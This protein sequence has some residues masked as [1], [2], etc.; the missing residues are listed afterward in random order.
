MFDSISKYARAAAS[1]GLRAQSIGTRRA[2]HAVQVSFQFSIFLNSTQAL[3]EPQG[4]IRLGD[5][6]YGV[7]YRTSTTRSKRTVAVKVFRKAQGSNQGDVF[8]L[9]INREVQ[10]LR[11]L[12]GHPHIVQ[13]LGECHG[14]QWS[15]HFCHSPPPG[16]ADRLCLVLEYCSG[17]SLLD[18][19]RTCNNNNGL[20]EVLTLHIVSGLA[21]AL[22]HCHQKLGELTVV[23]NF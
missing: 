21:K 8:S 18:W 4:P 10:F 14:A 6:A 12:S 5:G 13:G 9:Q 23:L 20:G 19:I 7:V 2:S 11:A 16:S 1:I 15:L 22:S 17:G 3:P